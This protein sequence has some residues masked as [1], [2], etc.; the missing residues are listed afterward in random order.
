MKEPTDATTL[1]PEGYAV[2]LTGQTTL[3]SYA[4]AIR[5]RLEEHQGVVNVRD[6]SVVVDAA[7]GVE[8]IHSEAMAFSESALRVML[9][10][11]KWLRDEQEERDNAQGSTTEEAHPNSD[12]R[13]GGGAY[14]PY[15]IE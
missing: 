14:A 10:S 3:T 6:Y 2:I 1:I 15:V 13:S 8:T 12:A 11:L 9:G 5:P 7:T 4:R